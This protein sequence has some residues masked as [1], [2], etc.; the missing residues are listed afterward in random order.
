MMVEIIWL[1][2]ILIFGR[3]IASSVAWTVNYGRPP[4]GESKVV[5]VAMMLFWPIF[6]SIYF[7]CKAMAKFS[8][9]SS[10]WAEPRPITGPVEA[11]RN[12]RMRKIEEA[13]ED[14]NAREAD[15]GMELT[16]W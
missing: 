4:D 14:I 15:L 8:R 7:T 1:A 16:R 9:A 5:G 11:Y 12:R 3:H 6:L 13:R 10:F 2:G